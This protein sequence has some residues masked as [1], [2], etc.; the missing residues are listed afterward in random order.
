MKKAFEMGA[1]HVVELHGDGQY[2]FN[3][4]KFMKN[5]FDDGADF[6]LGN[7]FYNYLQP[8]KDK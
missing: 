4:V 2:D 8:L 5:K 1:T 7:R 3:Q 6:V